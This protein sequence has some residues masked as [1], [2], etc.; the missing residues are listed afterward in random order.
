MK[1][2]ILSYLE[3]A[4]SGLSYPKDLTEIMKRYDAGLRVY[5]L[6]NL[7]LASL[8]ISTGHYLLRD[9]Y[10]GFYK[11][12][13]PVLIITLFIFFILWSMLI[14]S[15]ID[16]VVL[17]FKK[18][19]VPSPR[20]AVNAA[21]FALLPFAFFS[22]GAGLIK[23]ATYQS[24][25]IIL[26]IIFLGGWSVYAFIRT[27]QFIYEISFKDSLRLF[28]LSQVILYLFPVLFL[29]FTA[30]LIITLVF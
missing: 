12:E 20:Y 19:R 10:H 27:L 4:H 28:I 30:S 18:D 3:L 25:F 5:Y 2:F 11:I 26:L 7:F 15:L 23:N 17:L 16:T 29:Y 22:A 13:L 8:S 24:L 9:Y 6:I 14:G 21:G 1:A